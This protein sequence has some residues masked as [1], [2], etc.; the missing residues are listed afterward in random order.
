[1]SEKELNDIKLEE[2][3]SSSPLNDEPE[4]ISTEKII[5]ELDELDRINKENFFEK[6][7]QSK[8]KANQKEIKVVL[9]KN[10]KLLDLKNKLLSQREKY[11]NEVKK[12]SY[13]IVDSEH[14]QVKIDELVM[15]KYNKLSDIDI[16]NQNVLQLRARFDYIAINSEDFEIPHLFNSPKAGLYNPADD[17][18]FESLKS[19]TATVREKFKQQES[20][21]EVINETYNLLNNT[22]DEIDNL[23]ISMARTLDSKYLSTIERCNQTRAKLKEIKH[24]VKSDE[25]RLN[26]LK[27]KKLF[28]KNYEKIFNTY[29]KD[30]RLLQ[31]IEFTERKNLFY[32][33]KNIIS[34]FYKKKYELYP[35][36][37]FL[38]VQLSG[39]ETTLLREIE[40]CNTIKK[41]D[42][43]IKE[44]K[45][46]INII[47][48]IEKHLKEQDSNLVITKK[49]VNEY[50]AFA[51]K[52]R[53]LKTE[54]ELAKFN[55][56]FSSFFYDMKKNYRDEALE[57][58]NLAHDEI[59]DE[60]IKDLNNQIELA[61]EHKDENPDLRI[62]TYERLPQEVKSEK[63]EEDT[64]TI[65]D[66]V[67]D[68]VTKKLAKANEQISK[69][70]NKL[71]KNKNLNA[72]VTNLDIS[73]SENI[74]HYSYDVRDLL[75]NISIKKSSELFLLKANS[76]IPLKD[77]KKE[78]NLCYIDS[79]RQSNI[80]LAN[81]LYF[82][83]VNEINDEYHVTLNESQ[84]EIAKRLSTKQMEKRTQRLDSAKF[85]YKKNLNNIEADYQK[86]KISLDDLQQNKEIG[87]FV[88]STDQDFVE[89][90]GAA[91]GK[92]INNY[93][94]KIESLNKELLDKLIISSVIY[95]F[96]NAVSK[97]NMSHK[98]LS[99]LFELIAKR[100]GYI[101][102]CDELA[103][104]GYFSA[105]AK[106]LRVYT[107]A[108]YEYEKILVDITTNE[109][110]NK[111][112]KK[113]DLKYQKHIDEEK[114]IREKIAY[115]KEHPEKDIKGKKIERTYNKL[116]S[117]Q[118]YTNA[119]E[120]KRV[121]RLDYVELS[122]DNSIIEIEYSHKENL[123]EVI[124]EEKYAQYF[125]EGGK[126]YADILIQYDEK[127]LSYN[128]TYNKYTNDLVNSL[129]ELVNDEE[130]DVN[131]FKVSY[132][133]SQE[134]IQTH[135]DAFNKTRILQGRATLTRKFPKSRTLGKRL[136]YAFV[137]IASITFLSMI[138][139]TTGMDLVNFI[140]GLILGIVLEILM[141]VLLFF[142]GSVHYVE[143]DEKQN[144]IC[145][146]KKGMQTYYF[147]NSEIINYYI[148]VHPSKFRNI[149]KSRVD[150]V[151]ET[152]A[153]VY[154]FDYQDKLNSEFII[155]KFIDRI[156]ETNED[157][158]PQKLTLE[159]MPT[160]E[161]AN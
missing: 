105:K 116:T 43:E 81:K 11:K 112:N 32:S 153:G 19:V 58:I 73:T 95:N 137:I 99:K 114:A 4:N 88:K 87:V 71:I 139:G 77:L 84:E 60:K 127:V 42:D 79:V 159:D 83:E 111:I 41:I 136:K 46:F 9:A 76:N 119:S 7:F 151:I 135:R 104:D 94:D 51:A 106:A 133:D 14:E 140:V 54:A 72:E 18:F 103:N 128:K 47:K 113:F 65:S 96:D 36:L 132:E 29:E 49:V 15:R 2:T 147:K 80:I 145:Y 13:R 108:K 115:I 93:K 53:A 107:E 118:H 144:I 86:Q 48:N 117:V 44:R 150:L 16:E 17:A 102:Y 50:K 61:K 23:V 1:M 155:N 148:E 70:N 109:L 68:D 57:A 8:L 121:A 27:A 123:E 26:Y 24:E 75:E 100:D 152:G 63:V 156:I 34:S 33:L 38:Q 125:K 158:V 82:E 142:M 40:R 45:N 101:A 67:I 91:H 85:E 21:H 122:K 126:K 12:T 92:E 97:V 161:K 10:Q 59:L 20:S 154:T 25:F 30:V 28:I 129:N 157:E 5:K 141:E 131:Y 120:E 146:D 74:L 134:R 143:F 98:K 90:Y 55:Y 149:Y 52:Y 56:E 3:N 37:N 64:Q 124:I 6:D 110:T 62:A 39:N 69:L 160:L 35:K 89:L 22:L 66:K 78:T 138:L 31:N 130:R